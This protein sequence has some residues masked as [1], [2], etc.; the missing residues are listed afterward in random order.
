[1]ECDERARR[2]ARK[3]EDQPFDTSVSIDGFEGNRG[4]SGRFAGLHCK[5]AEMDGSAERALDGGFQEV[6][7]AHGDAACGYNNFTAPESGA[8]GG[9]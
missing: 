5:S 3:A 8:E 1:M 7:L 6:K 4:E 2:V 9:F